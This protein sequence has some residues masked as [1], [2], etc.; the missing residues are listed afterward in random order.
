[1]V[2]SDLPVAELVAEH[3]EC[4]AIFSQYRIDYCCHGDIAVSE[5]ARR[6]NVDLGAL[7]RDLEAAIDRRTGGER[8]SLRDLPTDELIH[9]IVTT[10]H[11]Y[12][13]EALPFLRALASKVAAVHGHDGPHLVT[14]RDTVARLHESLIAHLDEEEHVTF[15]AILAAE[16]GE[17]ATQ[18]TL[19]KALREMR[20]E[21]HGV[22]E[23][24][25]EL[26]RASNDFTLPSGACNS[27]RTLY[28]ELEQL[29]ADTHRHVHIE[30]HILAPRLERP[31][32]V[33][34][35]A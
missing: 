34:G 30:N 18:P 29:E 17:A 32:H 19:A 6:R 24:L 33:Q 21:H 16:Q 28:A 27:Y 11:D 9:H 35:A 7:T 3:P 14:I 23:L 10:H 1:M 5:A 22:A 8:A 4:A 12:L 15:P 26:R 25:V 20:D 31:H 13:R 2:L